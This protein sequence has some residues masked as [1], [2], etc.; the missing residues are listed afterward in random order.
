[1]YI[2]ITDL[3][4]YTIINHQNPYD[5]LL[6][7][8]A[9]IILIAALAILEMKGHFINKQFKKLHQEDNDFEL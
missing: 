6:N 5:V 4:R 8:I 9:I 7:T 3:V 2:G 1:V